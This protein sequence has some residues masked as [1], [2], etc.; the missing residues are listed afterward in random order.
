MKLLLQT[1]IGLEWGVFRRF[2]F[3]CVL[4]VTQDTNLV[5]WLDIPHIRWS[6]VTVVT[7][8][9]VRHSWGYLNETTGE[10]HSFANG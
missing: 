7:Q 8:I 6:M 5:L 4:Q 2:S 9:S 3:D 10:V 1:G